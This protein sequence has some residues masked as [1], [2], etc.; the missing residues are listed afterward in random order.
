MTLTSCRCSGECTDDVI[1]EINAVVAQHRE[2]LG[3]PPAPV[4]GIGGGAE[5]LN[6]WHALLQ[7]NRVSWLSPFT[8]QCFMCCSWWCM[9]LAPECKYSWREYIPMFCIL[10]AMR[11]RP[12]FQDLEIDCQRVSVVL[13]IALTSEVDEIEMIASWNVGYPHVKCD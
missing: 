7:S 3:A 4:L 1:A 12:V 2:Q 9:S 11:G 13:W 8:E 6:W 5:V 10:S